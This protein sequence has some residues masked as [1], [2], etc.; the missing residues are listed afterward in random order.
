MLPG[1]I[2]VAILLSQFDFSF[3][4]FI[5]LRFLKVIY[6]VLVVI[7]LLAG[8]SLFYVLLARIYLEIVE[9]FFR[10]GENTT[11][12]ARAAAGEAPASTS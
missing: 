11:I 4:S 2:V 5:T 9:L 1:L 12:L 3:T 8:L 10:I 7:S 6:I